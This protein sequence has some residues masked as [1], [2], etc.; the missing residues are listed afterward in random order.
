MS[1]RLTLSANERTRTRIAADTAGAVGVVDGTPAVSLSE[2]AIANVT[3][4]GGGGSGFVG[5]LLLKSN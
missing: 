1:S 4:G 2:S 3:G 5:L